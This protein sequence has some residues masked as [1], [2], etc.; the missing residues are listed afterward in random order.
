MEMASPRPDVLQSDAALISGSDISHSLVSHS[1]VSD[2]YYSVM[3]KMYPSDVKKMVFLLSEVLHSEFVKQV[4]EDQIVLTPTEFWNILLKNPIEKINKESLIRELLFHIKRY[5]LL[6]EIDSCKHKAE[7][8]F[9]HPSIIGE[10]KKLLFSLC[11]DL[12]KEE[13]ISLEKLLSE[14]IGTHSAEELFFQLQYK[15]KINDSN[16]SPLQKAF[17]IMHKLDLKERVTAYARNTCSSLYYPI[18]RKPCGLAFIINQETFYK[19][20]CDPPLTDRIGTQ[21]DKD[22]LMQTFKSFCFKVEVLE[23]LTSSDIE[24]E[25]IRM[26]T[27]DHSSFDIFVLCIL[28]HGEKDHIYGVDKVKVPMKKLVDYFGKYGLAQTLVGKPKLFFFQSC[29]GNSFQ[30]GCP[31]VPIQELNISTDSAAQSSD[32]LPLHSDILC[33]YATVPDYVS[34]R[35]VSNGSFFIQCLVTQLQKYGEKEDILSI[36]TLTNNS[37]AELNAPMTNHAYKQMSAWT[38]TLRRKV[39]FLKAQS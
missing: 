25:V 7:V 11:E 16:L 21:V 22:A 24:K 28:S 29:Q 33:A 37:V 36:L 27:M 35:S 13:V 20:G 38:S 19:D 10:F 14:D 3:K 18:T 30:T 1:V 6:R 34:F 2:R 12:P 5:N 39:K 31:T 15:N 23:N 32:L 9:H 17:E 26:A 8:E 4:L